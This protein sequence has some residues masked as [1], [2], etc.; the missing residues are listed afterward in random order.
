MICRLGYS[1]KLSASIRFKTALR[2]DERVRFMDE[3]ISGVQVI[4]MYVWEK[5]FAKLITETR[6]LEMKSI[7]NS[8]YVRALHLTFNLF[9]NRLAL[10][11]TVL[12]TMILYG[13][14]SITVSKIFMISSLFQAISFA[15]CRT[16][17]RG[18]A[19][20]GEVY[21]STKRLQMF[22]EY[23][24]KNPSNENSN[25]NIVSDQ[26]NSQD[27]VILMKNVSTA[28]NNEADRNNSNRPVKRSNKVGTYKNNPN[29]HGTMN[30]TSEHQIFKLQ[31]INLEVP[32][33]KLV[34]VIGSVGAG[35][36]TLMQVLLKEL[37]IL[38]GSMKMNGTISYACQENW[39]FAS[40]VRQNILFGQQM[41]QSR[42]DAVI[43]CCALKTDFIQLSEGDM[44][45]VGE[46]GSGLS[47]GQ[48]ARIKYENN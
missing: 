21:V 8:G 5:S 22:L 34:F 10:F 44:T 11:C 6:R 40:T 18:I 31:Q 30:G 41:D 2:S 35:K 19:E 25:G 1:G 14:E 23:K 36:S 29:G 27:T 32:K 26:I 45:V 13:H 39:I 4:K 17:V 20:L 37:P 12:S 15:M 43:Q 42:Y 24:E 38:S 46:N 3:I 16:F 9:A 7:L 48:K 47:G 33:G 28:W